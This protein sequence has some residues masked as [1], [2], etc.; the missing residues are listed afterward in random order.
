MQIQLNSTKFLSQQMFKFVI[1]FLVLIFL[2][3]PVKL[4]DSNEKILIYEDNS[5]LIYDETTDS[6]E[7][8]RYLSSVNDTDAW[9][10]VISLES[11]WI[12]MECLQMIMSALFFV[13]EPRNVLIVGLGVGILAQTLDDTLDKTA[14]IDVVE[15]DPGMLELA[16]KYFFFQ[17]SER[18]KIFVAD[19]FDY[20]MSLRDTQL[21]D[22]IVL[23][24]FAQGNNLGFNICS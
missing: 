14:F 2:N 18:V 13:P 8:F 17:P 7:T 9:Q 12:H 3:S 23:D 15:I 22:I 11:N 10:G 20:I 4:D 21:Y 16:K 1:N 6:G 24:A 5:S 19:G